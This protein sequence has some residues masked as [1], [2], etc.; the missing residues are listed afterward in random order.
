MF[1][2]IQPS[3]KEGL[4]YSEMR[5]R[6]GGG[7]RGG[8]ERVREKEGERERERNSLFL[9]VVNKHTS[10]FLHSAFAQRGTNLLRMQERERERGE[11]ERERERGRERERED[12]TNSLFPRVVNKHTSAFL[13]SALAQRGTNLLRTHMRERGG[14]E[15]ER[16]RR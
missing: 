11:R 6:G 2:L 1:F 16:E 12:K 14:R 5:E 7:W 15:R 4:I 9:R 10:V 3:P 8:G 13:Y